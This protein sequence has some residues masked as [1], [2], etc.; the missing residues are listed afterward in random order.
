MILFNWVLNSAFSLSFFGIGISIPNKRSTPI[1][2]NLTEMQPR[3]RIEQANGVS[4]ATLDQILNVFSLALSSNTPVQHNQ[5][6]P[7]TP[8][9]TNNVPKLRRSASTGRLP[10]NS[11][12]EVAQC[13]E[14]TVR[15]RNISPRN[16]SGDA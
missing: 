14:N 13:L 6:P 1:L 12:F 8:I 16:G 7:L 11:S 5:N 10:N 3:S 9:S 2:Q 4:Q 15:R